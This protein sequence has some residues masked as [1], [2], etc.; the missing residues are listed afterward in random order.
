M[1][2][3]GAAWEKSSPGVGGT[4]EN[5]TGEKW[6][7]KT[8]AW[9]AGTV[10]GGLGSVVEG[11]MEDTLALWVSTAGRGLQGTVEHSTGELPTSPGDSPVGVARG[12][13][14][15]SK[16]EVSGTRNGRSAQC[17][18]DIPRRRGS[19]EEERR[20]EIVPGSQTMAAWG[21]GATTTWDLS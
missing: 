1:E 16:G 13:A 11:G 10:G 6:C 14:E 20:L 18:A 9:A 17:T 15:C 8:M 4:P 2:T 5:D 19:P 12:T 3:A 7:A 21:C